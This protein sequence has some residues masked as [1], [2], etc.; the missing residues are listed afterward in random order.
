[1]K[2]GGVL[3]WQGSSSGSRSIYFT[4][5]YG[6]GP[7]GDR[8]EMY[9]STG[10]VKCVIL[11]RR[12]FCD[13]HSGEPAPISSHVIG[14]PPAL[15]RSLRS[16]RTNHKRDCLEGGRSSVALTTRP[17]SATSGLSLRK[18][19]TTLLPLDVRVRSPLPTCVT[20]QSMDGTAAMDPRWILIEQCFTGSKL[21]KLIS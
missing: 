9:R 8:G 4:L 12:T 13:R 14:S 16:T 1:M 20:I 15:F 6:C 2:R 21:C 10:M 7:N 19:K 17:N 3:D 11:A 5:S 18:M